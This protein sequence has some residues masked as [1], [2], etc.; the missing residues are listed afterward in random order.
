MNTRVLT[1]L[2]S[3]L[4]TVA[5][6]YGQGQVVKGVV[7]DK[8]DPLPGVT[9]YEKGTSGNGTV[10]DANGRYQLTLKNKNAT[11][12]FS[13]V[14][15]KS[16]EQA[17]GS[18][19]SLNVTLLSNEQ[20]LDE[21]VVVGFGQEKKLT[22]TGSVSA[23]SGKAIRENPSASLQN[24]LTG[25]LPGFFSQQSS[26]RPGA[27]GA[28]FFIRGVS[29]Y[30]GNNQPL[31]IVDDIEYS[32]DQFARLDPN[33]IESLSILKDA[34]TTA[35][36][37]V[38]GANGVVVVTTRRGQT[39]PPKVSIRLESSITQPT[40]LPK[41]LNSYETARLY[42]QAQI[43]DNVAN[44]NPN[45][46]PRFTDENLELFRTGEDPYGHPDVNWREVLFKK[47]SQQQRANLDLSGGT[48]RVKYFVSLGYLYQNGMLKDFG[49][50]Y[51]VNNN[52]YHQRYN[53]RSNLDL[54]VTKGLDLRVDLYGNFGQVNQP[55]VGSP[56]SAA[57]NAADDVFYDYSSFL[58]LAPFAYPVYNPDG[59]YGYSTWSNTEVG[60]T[61][62]V[63]NVVGR[64]ASY[65]Y[66]RYNE[67]N[68]NAIVSANQKLDFITKGLKITGRAAYTSNY[69]Y[70]RQMTRDQFPSFIYD[71]KTDTYAPR[72]PNIFRFRRFF[73][74]YG[75]GSTSRVLNLQGLLT[76]DRT[77]RDKHH[78]SGL[79]L[80]N[81]NTTT[82]ASGSSDA[83]VRAIYN[84]IPNNFRG[85]SARLG[86]D[87][88][89]KYLFQLNA[90][91]NGSTRFT[92][93]NRYGFFP[94]VSAGW[95]LSEEPFF[96][97]NLKAVDL[98]KVRGSYGLVG[99]DAL[100][101]GFSYYY[102]QNYTNG[103]G[104][105]PADFGYSNNNYTGVVEGRLANNNVTWEKEKKL[106]LGV[107]LGLF[108]SGLTGTF[109]FFN[110][111]RYD[112]L[113]TRGTVSAIFG[114]DLPPVNLGRVQNRGFEVELG[115]DKQLTPDFSL[116]VKGNYSVAK[117][118]ILFQDEPAPQYDYQ[119]FTGNSIG[120]IRVYEFIG[121]YKDAD[122]IAS[123]PKT[124]IPV[125]PGDLKYADLNGDGTINEFDTKVTGFPNLPNTN[126]GLTLSAR[127]KNFS[128]SALLQSARNFNVRG[129]SESIRA[130]S[131]N[132][133]DVHTQAWTPEL[134]DDAQ[135]PRLSLLGGIS[136][137]IAYPS[138]FWF[139]RG[140]YVRLRNVQLNYDLP[141]TFTK[142]FGIPQMR[143]YTTGANLLTFTKLSKRYEFDPEINSGTAKVAYP[144]QRVLNLGI[145]ASF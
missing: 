100:G 48:D 145:S 1:A 78:L 4:L 25:R 120:Q 97:D 87:Y 39:G 22:L 18:Q 57:F 52:F 34:S 42:N 119:R 125:Q 84:F 9:V 24:A 69:T 88:K 67:S 111:E 95:V 14:G 68:M 75:P 109:D 105:Q 141:A 108:N 103:N 124:A 27:D 143:V 122:D 96:K 45:F 136:D 98:L 99:N 28:A 33:E 70:Y 13:F 38:R 19:A 90:G 118:K 35:I 10:T 133:M 49:G 72:D 6:A 41:Y 139:I 62:N 81:R 142:K 83:A 107:E 12:V 114:Q 59:S 137:P 53:Y 60:P 47:W 54:N 66:R 82:S 58:T 17:V 50:D 112:I 73:L 93:A 11:L 16:V 30:N 128:F 46:K 61:Y 123:S 134:G 44:P 51:G 74:E 8:N 15:Y 43:N 56:S 64:L 76:Y 101:S 3:P 85:Y 21:V 130:F 86:Y 140:D 23:V 94:A 7:S 127:Y 32:Y 20:A 104:T 113:T 2:C 79:V 131:S 110:N 5:V 40:K 36:Y 116:S 89:Q 138:T 31:I 121:F 144:P 37:G 117:N 91:Y 92:S 55:R 132:L 71:S 77:F 80:I 126:I 29:S 115:Y 65:G 102:Q 129:V 106:D 63:N 135:Y 26:G